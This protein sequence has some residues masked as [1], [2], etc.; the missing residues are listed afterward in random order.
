M[1]AALLTGASLNCSAPCSRREDDGVRRRSL[2]GPPPAAMTVRCGRRSSGAPALDSAEPVASAGGFRVSQSASLREPPGKSAP[3]AP[4]WC[5]RPPALLACSLAQASPDTRRPL[6]RLAAD[7]CGMPRET[8]DCWQAPRRQFANTLAGDGGQRGRARS[9][10]RIRPRDPRGQRPTTAGERVC[11]AADRSPASG[12]PA[13]GRRSPTRIMA[14]T[15][16]GGLQDRRG[17]QHARRQ[18]RM[19]KAIENS[20][21]AW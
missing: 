13:P 10:T 7:G 17:N 6:Q 8:G 16:T 4:G 12:G 5:I 2:C 19:P 15:T 11:R 1:N 3:A 9:R 18:Y 14:P 21:G 20:R